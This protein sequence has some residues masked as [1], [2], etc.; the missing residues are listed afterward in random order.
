MKKVLI[1]L[2]I[3]V[4]AMACV[5]AASAAN[6]VTVDG[7]K[8]NMVD[9]FTQNS[10]DVSDAIPMHQAQSSFVKG[11]E[12]IYIRTMAS[13]ATNFAIDQEVFEDTFAD[14]DVVEKT[15]NGKK[16]YLDDSNGQYAFSYLNGNTIVTVVVP[17]ESYLEKIII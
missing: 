9:G 15:I 2:S 17:D 5:T 13:G 12:V 11:D 10:S 7:I 8:F 14:M 6:Q 1:L 4:L 3:L 16:G